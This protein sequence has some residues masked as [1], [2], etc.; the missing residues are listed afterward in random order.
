MCNKTHRTSRLG[1]PASTERPVKRA[2][3]EGT[4][5][6]VFDVVRAFVIGAAV[7]LGM[8]LLLQ[9]GSS[10]LELVALR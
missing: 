9:A 8:G 4:M 1:V 3:K 5:Q 7:L 10:A 6:H 2:L